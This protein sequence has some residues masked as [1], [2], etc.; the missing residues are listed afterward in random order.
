MFLNFQIHCWCLRN[1]WRAITQTRVL[2]HRVRHFLS[3]QSKLMHF[4]ML[5]IYIWKNL[6]KK[7]YYLWS[8]N[9][10]VLNEYTTKCEGNGACATHVAPPYLAAIYRI[11]I[12]YYISYYYHHL[13]IFI[14]LYPTSCCI[15]YIVDTVINYRVLP[16]ANEHISCITTLPI[17][18]AYITA[19]AYEYHD[20]LRVISSILCR[21]P[22]HSLSR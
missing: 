9:L 4:L 16:K 10:R 3:Q 1:G 5:W 12:S 2:D 19:H 15:Q 6:I 13:L 14:P 18:S 8:N 11:R 7:A 17:Y 21:L 20:G 22:Y